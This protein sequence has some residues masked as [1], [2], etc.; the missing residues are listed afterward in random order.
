[1]SSPAGA[2]RL[3]ALGRVSDYERT[4]RCRR[5][6]SSAGL[7]IALP[8]SRRTKRAACARRGSCPSTREASRSPGRPASCSAR[9][10]VREVR[11]RDERGRHT[12][13]RRDLLL[14]P[15]GGLLL[16]TPGMRELQLW[17]AEEGVARAFPDVE[18][19]ASSCRYAD[20]SHAGDAGCAVTSAV[21][22]GDLAP[23]RLDSYLRLAREMD[24]LRVLQDERARAERKAGTKAPSARSA[25]ACA[26]RAAGTRVGLITGSRGRA[27]AGGTKTRTPGDRRR[28]HR[29]RGKSA[30]VQ[31]RGT[32]GAP[33]RRIGIRHRTSLA[34]MSRT[35]QS[36]QPAEPD[37]FF[38]GV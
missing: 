18:E 21:E 7:P 27:Q 1:M 23:E 30:R 31:G 35:R 33:D 15:D 4:V 38:A 26:K 9:P 10:R 12:T 25:P 5:S 37:R 11:V 16:D 28:V 19:L 13:A 6:I 36:V 34:K 22:Q 20:C 24:R 2:P 29:R 32:V 3:A 17:D 8:P 14:L